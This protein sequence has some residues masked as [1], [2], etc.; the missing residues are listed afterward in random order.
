MVTKRTFVVCL[1]AAF[2]CGAAAGGAYGAYR[3]FNAGFTLLLN[4]ALEKDAREVSKRVEILL[5]LRKEGAEVAVRK[6]ENGLDDLLVI[7]DP[8]QPYPGLEPTTLDAI[9]KAIESAKEYR[10]SFPW[11]GKNPREKMVRSLFARDLYK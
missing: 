2:V 11:T 3:G 6:L 1:L 9:R 7:F 5:N 10:A 8:D 4:E